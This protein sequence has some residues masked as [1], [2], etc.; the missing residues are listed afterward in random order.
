YCYD[1]ATG[2]KLWE[3]N[4][5]SDVK[6]MVAIKAKCLQ[7]RKLPGGMGKA[8]C[9]VVAGGVLIV[10]QYGKGG[11]IPLR[12][13]DVETGKTLWETADPVTGPEATPAVWTYQGK[14]YLVAGN[15]KGELRMI[16]PTHGKALWKVTDLPPLHCAL[17]TSAK[18][19]FVLVNSRTTK[20][21]GRHIQQYVRTCA[22]RITP[23]KAE[24]AW[25]AP[26][27]PPFLIENWKDTC[28]M[29]KVLVRDGLVFNTNTSLYMS[30]LKEETGEPVYTGSGGWNPGRHCWLI[31]DRL[32]QIPSP[33]HRQSAHIEFWTLD[34]KDFHQIG[35]KYQPE[36]ARADGGQLAAG[37]DVNLE[38]PY[39]DGFFFM[40][41]YRGTVICYDL[42]K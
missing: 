33:S 18:H 14:Q 34:P 31:E 17:T 12:G 7:D 37:Y 8:V 1:A 9:P 32:V 6:P 42:R 19:V 23:E 4:T 10:P 22:Y 25:E 16:D 21:E 15:L 41:G 28:S 20:G 3:D 38:L 30:V 36:H 5:G 26:D 11:D 40:R 39:A 13:M 27:E 29:R 24:R 35:S 2:K